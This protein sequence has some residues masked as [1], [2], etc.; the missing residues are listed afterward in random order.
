MRASAPLSLLLLA[1]A[2]ACA[3][4]PVT[5]PDAFAVPLFTRG[6]SHNFGAAMAGRNEVPSVD[7]RA[8]GSAVFHLSEDGTALHYQLM[9]AGLQ[10]VT[11]AHIH[12]G[13]PTASGPFV[14]FLF[15]FVPGGVSENGVLARG[16]IHESDLIARANIGFGATMAELV[17]ALRSGN[18]YV[19]AHTVAFPAGEIRGQV[20]ESGPTS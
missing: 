6:E 10:N 12:I 13:P 8:R 5:A 17:A 1:A 15:G 9:T 16:T 20:R 19:N 11:Q 2:A 18:A 14:V 7:T 4:A 3:E